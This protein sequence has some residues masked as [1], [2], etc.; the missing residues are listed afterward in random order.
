MQAT[1]PVLSNPHVPG[2][3]R[4][5]HFVCKTGLEQL[6]RKVCTYI[7][8][9]SEPEEWKRPVKQNS[10]SGSKGEE[11]ELQGTYLSPLQ[12][13]IGH[14]AEGARKKY[15]GKAAKFRDSSKY[16]FAIMWRT[17]TRAIKKTKLLRNNTRHIHST[18]NSQAL[19]CIK[20]F[21]YIY[22]GN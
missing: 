4:A 12:L 22:Y 20:R 17:T 16:M 13:D 9:N 5:S 10:R 19:G 21:V 11:D 2:G 3:A 6:L 15:E 14:E 7:L 18:L 8:R 1:R